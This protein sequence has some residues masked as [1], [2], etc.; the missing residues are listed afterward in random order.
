MWCPRQA[1]ISAPCPPHQPTH[2]TSYTSRSA[3]RGR[4]GGVPS[5]LRSTSSRRA[6]L[7]AQ[8]QKGQKL[9]EASGRQPSRLCLV[10]PLVEC[11]L[12]SSV[13]PPASPNSS[14]QGATAALLTGPAA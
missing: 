1:A 13:Y 10:L 4:S 3:R 9:F 12:P 5:G 6:S 8:R 2:R 7:P 11:S 14:P